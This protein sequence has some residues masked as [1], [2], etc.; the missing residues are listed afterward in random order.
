MRSKADFLPGTK[1]KVKHWSTLL[2]V[3]VEHQIKAGKKP[4]EMVVYS[5]KRTIERKLQILSF[6]TV[7]DFTASQLHA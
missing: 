1:T 6:V 2:Y 7:A 5:M 4:V 3:D